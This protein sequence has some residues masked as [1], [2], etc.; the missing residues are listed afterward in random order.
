MRIK[1]STT[2]EEESVKKLKRMAIDSGKD[3]NDILE[4]MLGKF[5]PLYEKGDL[6]TVLMVGRELLDTD[7]VEKIQEDDKKAAQKS[8]E[9][10]INHYSKILESI[11]K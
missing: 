9:F 11:S 8:L 3:A 2:L 4:F 7:A 6:E 1:F 5:L 10:H